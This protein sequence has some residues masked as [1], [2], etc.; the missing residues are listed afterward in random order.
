MNTPPFMHDR[1][2]T[3]SRLID[4]FIVANELATK[5]II[6]FITL[7]RSFLKEQNF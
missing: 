6:N 2:E 1:A 5:L 3:T 4:Y 7:I